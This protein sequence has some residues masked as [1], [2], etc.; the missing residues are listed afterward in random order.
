MAAGAISPVVGAL[1]AEA[2]ARSLPG[3]VGAS[4][5][6]K[7]TRAFAVG[8]ADAGEDSFVEDAFALDVE[9]E[10]E[11]EVEAGV[12][13]GEGRPRRSA[14]KPDAKTANN[15]AATA[16]L[17]SFPLWSG[18]KCACSE[19]LNYGWMQVSFKCRSVE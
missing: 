15:M 3:A 19:Q 8:G 18:R 6:V 17:T 13:A 1:G 14:A 12:D 11:S 4:G 10:A 7:A 5:S 9:A 2:G 16:T